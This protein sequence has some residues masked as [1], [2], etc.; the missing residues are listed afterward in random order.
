MPIGLVDQSEARVRTDER[1]RRLYVIWQDPD[2]RRFCHVGHLDVHPDGQHIF[3]YEPDAGTIPGFD[4]FAAFPD[5]NH[6][7]RSDQLFPFFANRVLSPRRPEYETYLTALDIRDDDMV[8]VELLARAGGTRATDTVHIV[9]EPRIDEDGRHM[10][11][12]LASG[13]RHIASERDRVSELRAGDE[14]TLRSDH[15]NPVNPA[16]LLLDNTTGEP[17]GWVPDYLLDQVRHYLNQ[18]P[19]RVFVERASGT[20]VPAHLRLLCRLEALPRVQ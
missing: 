16:A 3:E 20:D 13:V 7:Y 8:P 5:L 10:L 15:D 6:T 12:F 1:T 17:V 19:V 11:L 14:L 18:G 2:T 9:P 4:G